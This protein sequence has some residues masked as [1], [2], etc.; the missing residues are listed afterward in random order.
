MKDVHGTFNPLLSAVSRAPCCSAPTGLALTVDRRPSGT[1]LYSA[2][3]GMSGGRRRECMR[4]ISN[5]V[6]VIYGMTSIYSRWHHN[7]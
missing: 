7:L 1:C 4:P 2:V 3:P 6:P 5:T